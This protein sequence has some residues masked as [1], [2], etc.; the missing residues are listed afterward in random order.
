MNDSLSIYRHHTLLIITLFPC[1][2]PFFF[3]LSS[4]DKP[5]MA[6]WPSLSSSFSERLCLNM[7]VSL[8]S[9]ER[10][11]S[12]LS[13]FRG[14]WPTGGALRLGTQ[15]SKQTTK[16]SSQSTWSS[17]QPSALGPTVGASTE[18]SSAS[19]SSPPFPPQ[20]WWTGGRHTGQARRKSQVRTE[21]AAAGDPWGH[22]SKFKKTQSAERSRWASP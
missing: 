10:S 9:G 1:M 22:L 7:G 19:P 15:M 14:S 20:W 3:F 12:P 5:N 16:L 6:G 4:L 21:R 18:P 11:C 8:P 2:V 13:S 17:Q